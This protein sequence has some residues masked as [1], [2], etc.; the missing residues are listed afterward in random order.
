[1]KL[2]AAVVLGLFDGPQGCDPSF[3]AWSWFRFRLFRRYLS[4]RPEE[5]HWVY[6]LLDMVQEGCPGHGPVYAL[7]A[8]AG[9]IG[10]RWD[11]AVAKWERQSLPGLSNLAGPIQ[12]VKAAILSAWRD[13]VS[14]DL[15]ARSGFRGG[16]LLDFRVSHQ[17]LTS[18]HF[19]ERDKALL[20][21]F[22]VGG[23]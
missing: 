14:A 10:F 21:G 16:P 17:L 7:V 5:V 9:P 3:V 13:K 4:Y 15:C 22:M 1:M 19:R 2:R 23:V 20:R 18:S 11:P 8:S 6:R 12:H